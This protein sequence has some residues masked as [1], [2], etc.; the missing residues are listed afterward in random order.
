V[1]E[2]AFGCRVF[3]KY[4]SREFSG[5]AY[6]CE[7]HAGHHV[8][9]EGYIVELLVDGRP[10]EPGETGEVVVTDLNNY[11]MPFLRYRIGDLAVAMADAPC[12]CGRGGPRIGAIHGRVQSI[13]QGTDGRYVPGTF[14]PHLLKDYEYA[15]ERFQIVQDAPGAITLRVV[16]GGRYSD[17]VLDE[18][19]GTIRAHLGDDLAV[20]V[21]FVDKVEMVRTGKR[22]TSVSNL[23]ID[24]QAHAP[25]RSVVVGGG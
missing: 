12:S 9:S 7:A 10:A 19:L 21:A 16:R 18:V 2:R 24:F 3:D 5:I 13:I 15:I 8:V 23:D 14:F 20:E 6:E 22:M 25:K 17:D 4:G 1:I 11:A